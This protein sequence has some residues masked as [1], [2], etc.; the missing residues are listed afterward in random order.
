M[1]NI[2]RKQIIHLQSNQTFQQLVFFI[3]ISTQGPV[4]AFQPDESIRDLLGFNKITIYEEYI[5][6]LNPFD[7]SSFDNIFLEGYIAKGIIFKTKRSGIIHNFT[8]HVDLRYKYIEKIRSG[9][10]WYMMQSKDIISSICFKITKENNKLVSVND[11]LITFRASI[12]EV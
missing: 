1:K 5:L 12:K 6:S 10:Q 4:I 7:I 3:E 9:V 2:L 11:R 8:M